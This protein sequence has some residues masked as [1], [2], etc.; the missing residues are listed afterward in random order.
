[1]SDVVPAHLAFDA[2]G[3]LLSTAGDHSLL[4]NLLKDHASEVR[5]AARRGEKRRG[6]GCGAE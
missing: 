3:L 5:A 4:Q 2:A 6:S 1:M